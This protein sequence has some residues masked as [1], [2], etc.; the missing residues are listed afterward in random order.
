ME[1]PA[2]FAA[3]HPLIL[4]LIREGKVTGIR[5]DHLDGLFDPGGYVDHLQ[6]A[7]FRSGLPRGAGSASEDEWRR[8]AREWREAEQRR[9]PGG[10]A[11][12]PFWVV[13]E[14]ILSPGEA[15]PG[16]WPL[17]GTSGYDFM[18]DLNR[19]FVDPA[20]G[21]RLK[22]MYG[23]F[24]QQTGPITSIIYECKKLITWTSMASEL[25]VLSF[26][27][28][29]ISEADRRS[30]DF[31]LASL[32]EALREVVAAFPVY[33][34]YV[35]AAGA[36]AADRQI[37][38][39]ALHIAARRNPAMEPSV[40]RFLRAALLPEPGE[41][42]TEA[43]YERRLQFA[44]KFQQYTGPVQ[45]K[46]VEDTAFYR[47]NLLLSLNEVGGDPATLRRAA[48][49]VPRGQSLPPCALAIRHVGDCDP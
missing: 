35:N 48:R 33:R 2:V 10:L 23:R 26:A 40:F 42:G 49:A 20:S 16:A 6:N 43:E 18:N 22:K 45:A 25:N 11:D 36:G 34:T 1:D 39:L 21:K 12:R 15:L 29:R 17:Y 14:K 38:E 41:E 13:A 37:I 9:D 4:R 46:G 28:N 32:T 31:T 7:V 47:Y 27:L 8:A 3:T 5:L 19:L 30:R 24:T 44:M